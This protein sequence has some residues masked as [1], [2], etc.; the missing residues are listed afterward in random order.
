MKFGSTLLCMSGQDCT[1]HDVID[2][3]AT[4]SLAGLA[5]IL[6]VKAARQTRN[7]ERSPVPET[8]QR[9]QPRK[10]RSEDWWE[11]WF[12]CDEI[13]ST[14]SVKDVIDAC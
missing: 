1:I 5:A 12:F 10:T 7:D 4:L 2:N 3:K 14:Y 8:R 13:M 6:R 11:G 9:P